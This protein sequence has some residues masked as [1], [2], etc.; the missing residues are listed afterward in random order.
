MD[1]K[2]DF[3]LTMLFISHNMA[4]VQNIADTVAVMYLGKLMGVN[5][6][7]NPGVDQYKEETRRLL[8]DL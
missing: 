2:T 3:G 5:P 4:V 8:S 1:L 6:F 7:D